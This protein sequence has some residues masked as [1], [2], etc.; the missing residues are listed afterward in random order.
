MFYMTVYMYDLSNF[1]PVSVSLSVGV[2]IFCSVKLS[3]FPYFLV[4]I[5]RWG[6][7]VFHIKH[8]SEDLMY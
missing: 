1:F 5:N 8:S 6:L 2:Y 4:M 7:T 3:L